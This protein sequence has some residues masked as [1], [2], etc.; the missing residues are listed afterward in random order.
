MKFLTAQEAI[1]HELNVGDVYYTAEYG[2]SAE[3][4]DGGRWECALSSDGLVFPYIRRDISLDDTG[5]YDIVTP[6]GYGGVQAPST[7]A[8]T[9]FRQEFVEE[10]RQ[11]GLV[12]EFVRGHP[13]DM[14]ADM[15][16]AWMPDAT[17]TH[18]T[19]GVRVEA[20]PEEYF[21]QAEGRH[22]TAVRKAQKNELRIEEHPPESV[23]SAA[24]PFR[25]IYAE[26]MARVGASAR[27][28]LGDDYFQR[29]ASLG[30]DRLFALE[31]LDAEGGTLAAALFMTNAGRMHY[32]LSGATPE[33]QKL[34]ATNLII[35][36][37]I[38]QHLVPGD[39]LHLG[40]GV[41]EGDGLSK[42]KRSIANIVHEMPMCRTVVNT[43]AYD[44]F[45]AHA[46][47]PVTDYFPPYRAVIA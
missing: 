9:A 18:S 3:L 27:L 30:S 38:R 5:H 26:T 31:A 46:G 32:H 17:T 11:R 33:G 45:N 16:R 13:L 43:E 35:D 24:S 28:R 20:D 23:L 4:I 2:S 41:T 14:T 7:A 6:Y 19:F 37:A 42:F 15:V 25:Q 29:L 22:R 36:H 39:W 34:G 47:D 10:S 44:R 12:A 40:G 21:T 8:L 1:D